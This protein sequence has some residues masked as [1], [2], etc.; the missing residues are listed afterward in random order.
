MSAALDYQ[1]VLAAYPDD[2][3]PSAI[4]SLD[5]SGGLSGARLWRLSTPRGQLLLRRWPREHP[6][7]E[8]LEFIQAVLWHVQQEGFALVPLPLETRENRGYVEHA[9]HLWELAP[10]L[11][12]RSDY[13]EAPSVPRVA[14]ALRTLAEFHLAAASFPLAEPV[15]CPAPGIA[16][17]SEQLRALLAGEFDRLRHAVR[18]GRSEYQAAAERIT[19]LFPHAAPRVAAALEQAARAQ[20]QVVPCLRDIW[21]RNVLFEGDDVTGLIDFGSLRPENIAADV[22]RL[23]GSMAEDDRALW[24][25]GFAAYESCRPLSETEAILTSAFDSSGVLLG[26]IN[27]L[28]WIY[29]RGRAF[30]RPAAVLERLDYFQRRLTFLAGIV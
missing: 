15:Q 16:E 11:P 23:L 22:A 10:W 25:Q 29:E 2:C 7:R 9:G 19:E 6:P 1:A 26:G 14:N 3:R 21:H 28:S 13:Q 17:R 5:A 12:G 8:R 24:R 18:D 20:V 4:A 30:D 27:W